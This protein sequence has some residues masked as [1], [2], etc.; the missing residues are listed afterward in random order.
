[1]K[2]QTKLSNQICVINN[3]LFSNFRVILNLILVCTKNK[4]SQNKRTWCQ[5]S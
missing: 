2:L 3:L 5:H 1:V 4:L